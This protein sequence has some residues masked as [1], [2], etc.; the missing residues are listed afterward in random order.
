[1]EELLI[2]AAEAVLTGVSIAAQDRSTAKQKTLSKAR[3]TQERERGVQQTKR[4]Q[5]R[6]VNVLD[7]QA[8]Q[9]TVSGLEGPSFGE[10]S[11][12][13]FDSFLGDEQAI[14]LSTQFKIQSQ[15]VRRE[16]LEKSRN[17]STFGSIAKLGLSAFQTVEMF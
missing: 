15:K 8:S 17:A 14:S 2:L 7:Q 1:M 10:L 5:D 16:E 13:S 12:R 11:K 3:E 4:A 6:I 9:E